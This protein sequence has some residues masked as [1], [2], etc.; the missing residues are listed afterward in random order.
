MT[1]LQSDLDVYNEQHRRPNRDG[2]EQAQLSF[3]NTQ[4]LPPRAMVGGMRLGHYD[5]ETVAAACL[6]V[7]NGNDSCDFMTL[8]DFTDLQ[9]SPSFTFVRIHQLA[10]FTNCQISPSFTLV[11][12][13]AFNHA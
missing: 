7:R 10:D 3:I 8:A 6:S 11:P 4:F 2:S 13:A 12:S 1:D 5:K 9:I